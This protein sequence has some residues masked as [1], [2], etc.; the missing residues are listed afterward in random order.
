MQTLACWIGL[1]KHM[2]LSAS[3]SWTWAKVASDLKHSQNTYDLIGEL[4]AKLTPQQWIAMY[5][6]NLKR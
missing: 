5:E 1:Q 4:A 3:E 6:K 2:Q